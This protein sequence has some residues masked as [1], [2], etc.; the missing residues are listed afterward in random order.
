MS[1]ECCGFGDPRSRPGVLAGWSASVSQTTRL[2]ERPAGTNHLETGEQAK[3]ILALRAAELRGGSGAGAGGPR[4][5]IWRVTGSCGSPDHALSRIVGRFW[6]G[7][8]LNE[9]KRPPAG[10]VMRFTTEAL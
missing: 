8:T 6:P 4:S 9:S 5:L 1:A 7:E 10:S 3:A 2:L